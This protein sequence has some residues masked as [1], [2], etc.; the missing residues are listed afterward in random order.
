MANEPMTRRKITAIILAAGLSSRMPGGAK[1]LAPLG[2]IPLIRHSVKNLCCTIFD[3]TIIVVGHN[4][5][6]VIDALDDLPVTLVKNPDYSDGQAS[7]I[8]AGLKPMANDT[9]DVLI[10]LG[11][12]PL[13]PAALIDKLC[14]AHSNN[15]A[16]DNTI[17]LPFCADQRRNPVL[18]GKAFFG[19]LTTLRGDMGARQII[20]DHGTSVAQIDWPDK[21]VFMDA[22]TPK[23]LA[24]IKTHFD[25][26]SP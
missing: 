8:K 19:L 18:F 9:D 17:T 13:L 3:E 2:G 24:A 26:Q 5:N 10:A 16:A 1:L 4:A 20:Q 6:A 15:P 14:K 25:A 11:D 23:M 22:D 21:A 12:M 7:S